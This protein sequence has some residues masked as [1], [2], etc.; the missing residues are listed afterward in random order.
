M[1]SFVLSTTTTD[2]FTK[3]L[4]DI[5]TDV[6]NQHI[7]SIYTAENLPLSNELR[8]QLIA[9]NQEKMQRIYGVAF[10]SQ[11]DIVAE[12]DPLFKSISHGPPH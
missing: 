2:D 8:P 1:P 11:G 4:R 6:L 9:M 12:I 3:F 5:S 7:D 10:S